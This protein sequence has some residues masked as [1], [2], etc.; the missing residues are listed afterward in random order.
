MAEPVM[1]V[2]SSSVGARMMTR[3]QDSS[4]S[5]PVVPL[6]PPKSAVIV[7]GPGVLLMLTSIIAFMLPL[8]SVELLEVKTPSI[9]MSTGSATIG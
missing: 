5:S 3:V 8:M 1:E 6:I 2:I 9:R 4:P 7:I